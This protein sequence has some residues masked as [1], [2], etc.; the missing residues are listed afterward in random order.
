MIF[1]RE[2]INAIEVCQSE[3]VEDIL[4]VTFRQGQCDITKAKE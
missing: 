3:L 4:K 2:N 1:E